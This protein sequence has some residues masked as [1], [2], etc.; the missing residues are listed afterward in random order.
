MEEVILTDETIEKLSTTIAKR[1]LQS[2]EKALIQGEEAGLLGLL[3]K[4][5]LDDIQKKKFEE[6]RQAERDARIDRITRADTHIIKPLNVE[7][8][9]GDKIEPAIKWKKRETL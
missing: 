4:S 8:V 3:L 6:Q 1:F 9:K 2:I 7:Y 5:Y